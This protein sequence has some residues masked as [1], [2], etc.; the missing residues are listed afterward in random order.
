MMNV[1][2]LQLSRGGL[3]PAENE[4]LE[5][6][7][8]TAWAMEEADSHLPEYQPPPDPADTCS[9]PDCRWLRCQDLVERSKRL[10]QRCDDPWV[11]QGVRYLRALRRCRNDRQER[12]LADRQ[13]VLD[14]AYRLYRSDDMRNWEI[15]GRLLAAE[16]FSA[17]AAKT[18][19]PTATIQC[20]HEL[21]FCV[22]PRL[23]SDIYIAVTVLGSKTFSGLSEADVGLIVMMCGYAFG[24]V[25]LDEVVRYYREPQS[26]PN[27]LSGLAPEELREVAWRL[28]FKA[29]VL[30]Q[31][32]PATLENVVR[33]ASLVH[34]VHA[35]PRTRGEGRTCPSEDLGRVQA[36]RDC[37]CA[38]EG[39]P[40]DEPAPSPGRPAMER[41]AASAA[42]RCPGTV[43]PRA[44][45]S[46]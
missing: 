34:A 24:P 29:C 43:L 5:Y 30:A 35:L 15:Q 10:R 40:T 20:Y 27:D 1:A 8:L 38:C 2:C 13:P 37:L 26:I 12:R 46:V 16:P 41:P 23:R 19:L 25:F 7:D 42:P 31:T 44:A 21:F 6:A 39:S 33:L 32:L 4:A 17:I 36:L 45:G 18:S 9:R 3:V 22:G 14:Q 11:C 28:R